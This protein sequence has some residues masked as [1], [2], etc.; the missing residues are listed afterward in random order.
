MG[1]FVLVL[2]FPNMIF[3][4]LEVAFWWLDDILKVCDDIGFMEYD[5]VLLEYCKLFWLL[6]WNTCLGFV[7]FLDDLMILMLVIM[8]GILVIY[9]LIVVVILNKRINDYY[10]VKYILL[11]VFAVDYLLLVL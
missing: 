10:G 7:Y 5:I 9:G 4:L 11:Q 1:K 2:D 8:A 6:I 3:L